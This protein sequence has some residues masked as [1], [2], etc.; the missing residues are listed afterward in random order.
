[1]SL[2]TC[3]ALEQEAR[4]IA[5]RVKESREEEELKP[6]NPAERRI[7]HMTLRELGTVDSESRG[8]GKDRRI[9]VKP[10]A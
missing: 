4:E 7:V 10:L 5:D 3:E 9:V 8:E 1:V 6:M 2:P